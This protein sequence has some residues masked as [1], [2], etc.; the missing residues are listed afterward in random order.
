MSIK[1]K[2]TLTDPAEEL[3]TTGKIMGAALYDSPVMMFDGAEAIALEWTKDKSTKGKDYC[4]AE[5]TY[6]SET[7]RVFGP[8]GYSYAKLKGSKGFITL[9]TLRKANDYGAKGDLQPGFKVD[10]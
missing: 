10:E 4:W 2:G 3:L 7:Y 1:I 6:K 9:S 8:K 5:V